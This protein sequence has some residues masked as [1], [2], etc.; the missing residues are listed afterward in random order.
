M[1]ERMALDGKIGLRK[2]AA[3]PPCSQSPSIPAFYGPESTILEVS[4]SPIPHGKPAYCYH[5]C[6]IER[7]KCPF[8]WLVPTLNYKLLFP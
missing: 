5:S 1:Q 4:L 2:L 8:A 6:S 3:I 7:N